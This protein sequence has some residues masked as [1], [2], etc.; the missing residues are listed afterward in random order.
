VC[1]RLYTESAFEGFPVAGIP[2]V[3]R[4]VLRIRKISD[5][6]AYMS[7]N[8]RSDMTLPLLQ[9]KALGIDDIMK[10]EWISA[11]SSEAIIRALE[12]LVRSGMIGEEDGRLTEIG[13]KVAEL[14]VDVDVAS[15]LWKSKEMKCSEEIVTIAAMVSVQ[16][17]SAS[18]VL[19][20][21]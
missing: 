14:G 20:R 2:E 15:M 21:H 8:R 11:P 19:S 6:V 18:A 17:G 3:Q 1:Y 10:F 12:R 5:F 9:L 16:V 13:T 7:W 4:F